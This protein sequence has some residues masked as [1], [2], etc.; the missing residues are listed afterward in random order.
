MVKDHGMRFAVG[1]GNLNARRVARDF[2]ILCLFNSYSNALKWGEQVVP[3]TRGDEHFLEVTNAWKRRGIRFEILTTQGGYKV[4]QTRDLGTECIL[5]PF[6]GNR[7]GVIGA[8]LLRL[9]KG[10]VLAFGYRGKICTYSATD[11]LPDVIP[12]VVIKLLLGRRSRMACFVHHLIPH[13]SS[14]VGSSKFNNLVSFLAQRISLLLIKYCADAVLV[15][16]RRLKKEL[17]SWVL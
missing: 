4:C 13:F 11:I 8:Y 5:L 14:R 15:P 17:I 7:L 12:A 6:E 16:N 9:L 10:A 3:I 2:R 1:S